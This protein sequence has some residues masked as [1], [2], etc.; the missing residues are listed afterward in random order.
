M[1]LSTQYAMRLIREGEAE[2][3]YRPLGQFNA[4]RKL[5]DLYAVLR[6]WDSKRDQWRFDHYVA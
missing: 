4:E 5:D 2:R 1:K 3:E 6:R